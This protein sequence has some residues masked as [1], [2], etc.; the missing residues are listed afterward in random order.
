ME[1]ILE[2]AYNFIRRKYET[3]KI[4]P[5]DLVKIAIKPQWNVILGTNGQCGQALNFTGEH[6]VYELEKTDFADDLKGRIGKPLFDLAKDYVGSEDMRKRSAGLAALN[7]LSQP[8]IDKERLEKEGVKFTDKELVAFT[9]SDDI[10]T[11]V[12]FGGVVRQFIGKC[13]E[14]HV[15]EMRPK[16]FFETTIIGKDVEIGPKDIIIHPAEENEE[17]LSKSDVVLITGSTLVNDT[18]FQVLGYCTKA[19][20]I[21]IYG[22]SAQLPP[23]FLF[24]YGINHIRSMKITDTRQFEIDMDNDPDLEVA[25]KA[26]QEIYNAY[27]F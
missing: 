5:G 16:S 20:I 11:V 8:L 15:T 17:I 3:G 1:N 9:G 22:P 21:N 23:D 25:I 24:Q 7:A 27:N 10:V 2:K 14:L 19:R 4:V 26:N 18:F 6:S 13:K 12:G